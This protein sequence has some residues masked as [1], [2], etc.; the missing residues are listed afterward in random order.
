MVT[1]RAKAPAEPTAPM[2]RELG[3]LVLTQAWPDSSLGL[4]F[5]QLYSE[6][7]TNLSEREDPSPRVSTIP[8]GQTSS[9]VPQGASVSPHTLPRCPAGEFMKNAKGRAVGLRGAPGH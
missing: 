9:G 6:G 4:S 1:D 7:Q 5:S 3:N 2:D 8:Q